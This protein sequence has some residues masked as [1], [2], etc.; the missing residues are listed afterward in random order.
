[1]N[2]PLLKVVD[3]VKRFPITGGWLGREVD[4][5]HAV[6]GVSFAV[7]TTCPSVWCTV[8]PSHS[9]GVSQSDG[10]SPSRSSASACLS[11][12]ITGQGL[13][14]GIAPPRAGRC[15]RPT[16]QSRRHAASIGNGRS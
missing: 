7:A 13:F 8:L 2:G 3:L 9:D 6:S 14:E 10:A 11:R 1:M 5:V 16:P 15:Q 4:S 12:W